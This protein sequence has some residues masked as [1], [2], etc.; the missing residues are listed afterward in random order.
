[1]S[2]FVVCGSLVLGLGLATIGVRG[3]GRVD[4]AI[5]LW[6]VLF[7]VSALAL[8]SYLGSTR[9]DAGGV[10]RRLGRSQQQFAWEEIDQIFFAS[11]PLGWAGYW[12]MLRP[13]EG[14]SV[15][16]PAP[17]A[18]IRTTEEEL[19]G[20]LEPIY[21]RAG[22]HRERVSAR[23]V[24]A[25]ARLMKILLI[26]AAAGVV[27]QP[28]TM[29]LATSPWEQA[30]WPGEQEAS[31]L[32]D[33]CSVVDRSTA[34]RLV[35][36]AEPRKRTDASGRDRSCRW[37]TDDRSLAV[38]LM[39]EEPGFVDG[40]GSVERARERY[41]DLALR[42][43]GVCWSSFMEIGDESCKTDERVG[44]EWRPVRFLAR[45]NNV[46]AMITYRV[47]GPT[48]NPVEEMAHVAREALREVRF[49]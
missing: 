29:F 21:A 34:V 3:A 18:G 9:V 23:P 37:D 16:L 30:W 27:A 17:I 19:A 15:V 8:P 25:N 44:A 11:A 33:A 49:S 14:R 39:L 13:K 47:D 26:A 4:S 40:D 7:G 45:E 12:T 35:P 20:R 22:E 6:A 28:L 32:P 1:M 46:I 38:R 24:S 42:Q 48:G 2:V 43:D 5:L 31:S 36:G 10:T 41:A